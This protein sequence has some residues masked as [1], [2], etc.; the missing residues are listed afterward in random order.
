M[1]IRILIEIQMYT[2]YKT[3]EMWSCDMRIGLDKPS[4]HSSKLL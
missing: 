1:E 3:V 2:Y 4:I